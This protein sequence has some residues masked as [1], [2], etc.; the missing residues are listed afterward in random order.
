EVIGNA[1]G[2]GAVLSLISAKC[3]SECDRIA[4]AAEYIEL[5][6][7]PEFQEEY[8]NNMVFPAPGA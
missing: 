5:S 2:T 1:A 6:S 4:D 8:L 3:L 7:S